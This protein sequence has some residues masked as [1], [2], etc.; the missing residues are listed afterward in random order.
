MKSQSE[1]R[2]RLQ[3]HTFSDT[4]LD[5]NRGASFVVLVVMLQI[6]VGLMPRV[7]TE[8]SHTQEAAPS[9]VLLLA[10]QAVQKSTCWP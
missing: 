3:T 1:A 4:I 2:P 10:K 6:R 7:L 8:A 5:F 9:P